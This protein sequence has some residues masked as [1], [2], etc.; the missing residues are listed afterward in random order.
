MKIV[1]FGAGYCCRYIIP[2]L[3]DKSEIIC[4]HNLKTKPEKYDQVLQIRRL[5]FRDFLNNKENLLKNV[6]H[7]LNSIPPL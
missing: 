4:T 1:F 7:I 6:T 5:S 3:E 2:N